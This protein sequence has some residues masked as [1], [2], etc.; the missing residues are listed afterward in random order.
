MSR[1]PW[2]FAGR[3][4]VMV[5]ARTIAAPRPAKSHLLELQ[6]FTLRWVQRTIAIITRSRFEW[7]CR[8]HGCD[9]RSQACR[10]LVVLRQAES[11]HRRL[12]FRYVGIK[13]APLTMAKD[14]GRP[15]LG[16]NL[17]ERR[18]KCTD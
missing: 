6:R 10:N 2:N 1:T 18:Q 15:V 11:S 9:C 7:R 13:L 14:C 12:T 16:C 5:L 8:W 17:G 3:S 4:R